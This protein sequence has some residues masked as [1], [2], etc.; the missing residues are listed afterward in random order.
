MIINGGSFSISQPSHSGHNKPCRYTC[1]RRSCSESWGLFLSS[2]ILKLMALISA[3]IM[4]MPLRSLDARK[5]V[6]QLLFNIIGQFSNNSWDRQQLKKLLGS[7][8]Q[9]RFVLQKRE[10]GLLWSNKLDKSIGATGSIYRGAMSWQSGGKQWRALTFKSILMEYFMQ[11]SI[12][13]HSNWPSMRQSFDYKCPILCQSK[14]QT[15]STRS[16]YHRCFPELARRKTIEVE[17]ENTSAV[18]VSFWAISSRELNI[19]KVLKSCFIKIL[20]YNVLWSLSGREWTLA[21]IV[22]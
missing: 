11:L 18:S 9:P 15:D 21:E 19:S 17:V 13:V 4:A 22:S 7:W 10:I 3:D 2:T 6:M 12:S 8:L 14:L 16:G 5:A 20:Q 1:L